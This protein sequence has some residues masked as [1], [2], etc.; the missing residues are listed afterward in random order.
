MEKI[1]KRTKSEKKRKDTL[2]ICDKRKRK[3]I[4]R[5]TIGATSVMVT[6]APLITY[7][8]ASKTG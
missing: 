2:G 5:I 3:I 4:R 6:F 1:N 8:C 7:G